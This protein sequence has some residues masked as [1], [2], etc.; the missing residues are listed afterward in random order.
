MRK[1]INSE[2]F[3]YK[4]GGGYSNDSTVKGECRL[5]DTRQKVGL[6]GTRLSVC[7]NAIFFREV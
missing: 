2:S 7:E 5:T 3:M 6:M 1:Y 4:P